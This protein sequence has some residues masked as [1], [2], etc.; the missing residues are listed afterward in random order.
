MVRAPEGEGLTLSPG[1]KVSA[2]AQL[3]VDPETE[4]DGGRKQERVRKT[5]EARRSLQSHSSGGLL[6][7]ARLCLPDL[8]DFSKLVP[9]SGNKCSAGEP[10][11]DVS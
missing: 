7:P 10:M 1:S 6:P 2:Q 11:E 9:L 3:H 8:L 5:L 4:R